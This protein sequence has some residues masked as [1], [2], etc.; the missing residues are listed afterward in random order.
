MGA[1]QL[2]K[3]ERELSAAKEEQIDVVKKC[4][5]NLIV[6]QIFGTVCIGQ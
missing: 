2:A 3:A 5:L 4:R 1:K 6:T